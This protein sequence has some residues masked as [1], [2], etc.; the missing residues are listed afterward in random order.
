MVSLV[1]QSINVWSSEAISLLLEGADLSV[2]S[3]GV[4]Y[5]D[6]HFEDQGITYHNLVRAAQ[7]GRIQ[8]RWVEVA[9]TDEKGEVNRNT[10]TGI[11]GWHTLPDDD[12]TWRDLQSN[13]VRLGVHWRE[14]NRWLKEEYGY[15]ESDIPEAFRYPITIEDRDGGSEPLSAV[16]SSEKGGGGGRVIIKGHRQIDQDEAILEVLRVMGYKPDRL[17]PREPG[18]KWVKTEVKPKALSDHSVVVN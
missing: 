11:F 2:F 9:D 15:S 17:P 14:V 5:P 12:E 8:V 16:A 7:E 10:V 3:M 1:S 4:N 6:D 18:K 13:H